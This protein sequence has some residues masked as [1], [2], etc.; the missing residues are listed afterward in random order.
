MAQWRERSVPYG[1]MRV[2]YLDRQ[3]DNGAWEPVLVR[4][5]SALLARD[6]REGDGL[7]CARYLRRDAVVGSSHRDAG[8]RPPYTGLIRCPWR[9]RL[10]RNCA[11]DKHGA[12]R[13]VAAWLPAFNLHAPLRDNID[14]ELRLLGAHLFGETK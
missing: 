9:T 5:P 4:A 7:Y 6:G 1:C 13:V 3:S 12:V 8:G 11:V 2:T 14:S 10:K